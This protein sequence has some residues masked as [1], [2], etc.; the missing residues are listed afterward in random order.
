MVRRAE[1]SIRSAPD[2]CG[3]KLDACTL[4]QEF[5]VEGEFQFANDDDRWLISPQSDEIAATDFAFDLEAQL[6]Q[7]PLHRKIEV[8]LRNLCH[9]QSGRAFAR[10]FSRPMIRIG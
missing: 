10:S 6:L 8:A 7:V 9:S 2:H 4:K 5:E 3:P 1:P